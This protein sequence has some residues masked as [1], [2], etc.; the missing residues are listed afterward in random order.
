M[1]EKKKNQREG[2]HY[3]WDK[4]NLRL[5]VNKIVLFWTTGKSVREMIPGS[6]A[7]L[8]K[9]RQVHCDKSFILSCHRRFSSF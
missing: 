5:L 7:N 8:Y 4:G 9:L 2:V 1:E 3:R 6:S